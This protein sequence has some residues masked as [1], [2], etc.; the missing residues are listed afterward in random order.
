MS[1]HEKKQR[2]YEVQA[3]GLV[4]AGESAELW[5]LAPIEVPLCQDQ[6]QGFAMDWKLR[7]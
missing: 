3:R 4:P 6:G 1:Q 7:D 2:N 5:A